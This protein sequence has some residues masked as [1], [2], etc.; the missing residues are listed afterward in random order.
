MGGRRSLAVAGF[1]AAL[2]GWPRIASAEPRGGDQGL[3]VMIG[4]PSGLTWKM[5][6]DD[7]VA[8]DAAA[9]IARSEFDL[10]TTLLWHN[11]DWAN[12]MAANSEFFSRVTAGGELPIYFGIG[13]RALFEHKTEFGI[14]FPVGVA[15]IPDNAKW[16]FFGEVAPVVRLTPDTGFNGDFAIGARYYFPAIRSRYAQ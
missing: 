7:A 4:N 10:H 15:Y 13:P 6:L 11:F 3:G 2:L 5:W 8:V 12:R 16:E 14:R 1:L 9:G